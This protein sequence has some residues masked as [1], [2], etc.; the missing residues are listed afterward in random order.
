M[1][2]SVSKVQEY[3][4]CP[5]SYFLTNI[6]K[7]KWDVTP[8]Q[9][10]EGIEKHDMFE[11]AI[12]HAKKNVNGESSIKLIE[13]GFKILPNFEQYR[14]D[15]EN[16]IKFSTDIK[17]K[18]GNPLPEH[19]EIKLYSEDLN[20]AGII[21]RVDYADKDILVLDYKTGKDHPIG[22]YY[23]QLATYVYMFEKKFGVTVTHWGIFFSKSGKLE[24]KKVERGE[25]NEALE[26]IKT[27]RKIIQLAS[28][29][30]DFPKNPSRL[31]NWCSWLQNG[32]CN[33]KI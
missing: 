23:F 13:D 6:K 4:K 2:L 24:I 7:E 26:R 17:N 5:F 19:V 1:R 33:G 25:I 29:N 14:S 3:E 27:T 28:A 22:N 20:F 16:F 15:C 21:D 9:L 31:C 11:K 10:K 12:L 30:K 32:K 18:G 8:I